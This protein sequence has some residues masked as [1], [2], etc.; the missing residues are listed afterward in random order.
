MDMA[1]PGSCHQEKSMNQ[2]MVHAS[3]FA[4]NAVST[5]QDS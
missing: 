4:E 3:A 5:G 2:L 1:E